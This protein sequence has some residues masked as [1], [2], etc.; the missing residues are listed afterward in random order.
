LSGVTIRQRQSSVT[1][2][3]Q[4]PI[5]SIGADCLA[6]RGGAGVGVGACAPN[7]AVRITADV[8]IPIALAKPAMS[9]YFFAVRL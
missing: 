7:E 8:K 3:T 2:D 6:D 5:K 1:T 4:L 9:L